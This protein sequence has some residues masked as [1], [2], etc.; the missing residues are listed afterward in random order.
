VY[1]SCGF[2]SFSLVFCKSGGRFGTTLYIHFTRRWVMSRRH[3]SAPRE[4]EDEKKRGRRAILR[5]WRF[6]RGGRRRVCRLRRCV[7]VGSA[8]CRL[9]VSWGIAAGSAFV[10]RRGLRSLCRSAPRCAAA[11]IGRGLLR[12][13]ASAG[14]EALL[15]RRSAAA[16]ISQGLGGGGGRSLRRPANNRRG[17]WCVRSVAWSLWV[18]AGVAGMWRLSYPR[19]LP[20]TGEDVDGRVGWTRPWVE[21]P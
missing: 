8:L 16:F 6:C 14:R 1:G 3:S 19:S 20:K 4:N 9:E 18:W 12:L 11:A 21:G 2:L 17:E 13:A 10:Y 5:S 7:F 15:L